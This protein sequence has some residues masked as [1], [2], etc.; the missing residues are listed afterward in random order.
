VAT[1]VSFGCLAP[2]AKAGQ[3]GS[4]FDVSVLPL[5]L[6]MG[7]AEWFL[8]SYRGRIRAEL[9]RAVTLADFRTGSRR[10]LARAAGGYTATLLVLTAP[11]GG[12]ALTTATGTPQTR[13]WLLAYLL[14]GVAL[15]AESLLISASQIG[16]ALWCAVPVFAVS[17]AR[18]RRPRLV[19][20]GA[21]LGLR[22]HLCGPGRHLRGRGGRHPDRSHDQP[23]TTREE[24]AR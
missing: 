23:L 14:L 21:G 12:L 22:R 8:R 9:R 7:A 15:F 4:G 16:V 17:G 13:Q 18:G 20:L 11:V 19:P 24:D 5:V 3:G 2:L 6:S 1:F 10:A